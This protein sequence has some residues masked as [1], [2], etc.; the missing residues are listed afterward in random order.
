MVLVVSVREKCLSL[1]GLLRRYSSWCLHKPMG[2]Y[3]GGLIL[4][5]VHGFCFFKL[6]LWALKFSGISFIHGVARYLELTC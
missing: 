3:M 2:I 6:F 5:L 1:Q 4:S